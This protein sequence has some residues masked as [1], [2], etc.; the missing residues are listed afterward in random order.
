MN[1]LIV[2]IPHY[3]A[4]EALLITVK[5]IIENFAIDVLVIDDG[6]TKKPL[7]NDLK[8]AYNNSGKITIEYLPSNLGIEKALNYGL[9][10]IENLDYQ[11]IGRLDAGDKSIENKF[12]KQV[13]YLEHNNDVYLLGS[14]GNIVDENYKHLYYLKP[15]TTYR[16]IKNKMFIN[17]CFIHPAVVFKKS[18]LNTIGYYP[19]DRKA[20]ED[21]AYFFNIMKKYKVENLPEVLI[22]I[23]IDSNGISVKKRKQ[24]IRSRIRVI[25]D[26][27][28]F[29]FYPIVG[30]LR[31]FLLLNTSRSLTVKLKKWLK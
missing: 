23:I 14:W 17:N 31:N 13:N 8:E 20:A 16:Q 27:F 26:N 3:N 21:Y 19:E 25:K 24:Q 4:P 12:R 22:D 28:Y 1:K 2:L 18:I 6:S 11:Y 29:G 30:I 5:S 10:M 7:L 15:P 9:K